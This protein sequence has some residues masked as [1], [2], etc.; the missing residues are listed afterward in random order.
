M[1]LLFIVFLLALVTLKTN[2]RRSFKPEIDY[3]IPVLD[4]ISEFDSSLKYSLTESPLENSSSRFSKLSRKNYQ[5][6]SKSSNNESLMSSG[7]TIKSDYIEDEYPELPGMETS[8]LI[9]TR[10]LKKKI[11]LKE[12]SHPKVT[13]IYEDRRGG[14]YFIHRINDLGHGIKEHENVWVPKK[15]D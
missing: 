15:K 1:K 3:S 2:R 13:K 9:D 10:E 11:G 6:K 5:Q 14:G 12:S 8:K 4:K 7:E